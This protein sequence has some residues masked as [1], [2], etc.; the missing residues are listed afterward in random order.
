MGTDLQV[1]GAAAGAGE[2]RDGFGHAARVLQHV[3][4]GR[5]GA[6]VGAGQRQG[7]DRE[8]RLQPAAHDCA[9]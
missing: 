8:Q 4:D 7:D 9:L 5:D 2:A 1:A 3:N 6:L